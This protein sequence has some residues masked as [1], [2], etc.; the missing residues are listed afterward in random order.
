MSNEKAELSLENVIAYLEKAKSPARYGG[1]LIAAQLVTECFKK[2]PSEIRLSAIRDRRRYFPLY[3][4]QR[5]VPLECID[6][7]SM[8][9]DSLIAEWDALEKAMLTRTTFRGEMR[10]S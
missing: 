4:S 5:R 9:V 10:A 8:E 6:A 1:L 2:P 3:L 7:I